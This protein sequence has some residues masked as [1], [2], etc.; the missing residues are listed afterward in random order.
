M[1]IKSV[2]LV[3]DLKINNY[4]YL[5]IEKQV[6]RCN[7]CQCRAHHKYRIDGGLTCET[8]HG[9]CDTEFIINTGNHMNLNFR[10]IDLS[11]LVHTDNIVT[12]KRRERKEYYNGLARTKMTCK[13]GSV[14][15]RGGIRSHERPKKCQDII[16]AMTNKQCN[17]DND[18]EST[19]TGG[20]G[21]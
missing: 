17:N 14:V 7:F 13:G 1:I 6:K 21:E 4:S 12:Q 20:S 9:I 2:Q 3:I 8:E 5:N 10:E 15:Y 16:L 19:T 18:P 11:D